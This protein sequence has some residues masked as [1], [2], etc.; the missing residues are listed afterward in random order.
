MVIDEDY[1][2]PDPSSARRAAESIPVL[3][4]EAFLE[5]ARDF[6]TEFNEMNTLVDEDEEEDEGEDVFDENSG[7]SP[8]DL[9]GGSEELSL[10]PGDED[11]ADEKGQPS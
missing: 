3:V 9:G 2:P 11:E 6:I 5:D 8:T 4:P 7:Y 1:E 10:F